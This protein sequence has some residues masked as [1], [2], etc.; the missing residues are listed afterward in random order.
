MKK[1]RFS[2]AAIAMI[3]AVSAAAFTSRAGNA[4]PTLYYKSSNGQFYLAGVEGY[5]FE[6]QWDHFGTCT[7]TLVNGVY[8]PY[9]A[10]KIVW[11]R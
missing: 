7:Y 9:K 4:A 6:C 11:I 10:G 8:K 5:D 1:T 2:V 3:I